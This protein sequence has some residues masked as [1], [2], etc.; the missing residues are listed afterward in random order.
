MNNFEMTKHL[1]VVYEATAPDRSRKDRGSSK[2]KKGQ[3]GN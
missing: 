3:G 1:K 2:N